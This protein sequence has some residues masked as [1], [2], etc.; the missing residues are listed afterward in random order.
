M[1]YL[2][3]EIAGKPLATMSIGC[4]RW[5]GREQAAQAICECVANDV[6]YLDTS[7]MYCFRTE[8]ENS[9][10]WVGHAIKENKLRDKVI[11]STKCSPGNGGNG[12]GEFNQANGFS[13]QTADQ[14][15]STFEQS[16]NRLQTDKLDCYQMW[17][18]STDEVYESAFKKCG[19]L[20]GAMK[21][22]D[23]GLFKHLESPDTPNPR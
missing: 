21:A 12:I 10:R 1:N 16:L 23:E 22:K 9:E 6:L 15:R 19:W 2:K 3:T 4:M 14:F 20:E 17:T 8:E 5:E 18:V 11:L 13:I 7:P